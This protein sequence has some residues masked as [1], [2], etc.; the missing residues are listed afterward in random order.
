M[1]LNGP[2]SGRCQQPG[3]TPFGAG[4]AAAAA[5]PPRPPATA[6]GRR[7]PRSARPRP[8]PG[9]DP[10][11]LARWLAGS[12]QRAGATGSR[13]PHPTS[14]MRRS[15]GVSVRARSAVRSAIWWC[16]RPSQPLS[17]L[18]ARASNAAMSRSRVMAGSSQPGRISPRSA[19]INNSIPYE[20]RQR[21]AAARCAYERTL[22]SRAALGCRRSVGGRL[23]RISRRRTPVTAMHCRICPYMNRVGGGVAP[24]PL[25]PPDMRVRIRRFVRPF[26]R[27]AAR[28]GSGSSG[29]G[30]SSRSLAGI[31]GGLGSLQP[32]SISC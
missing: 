9:P 3:R 10:P 31:P 8:W 29:R 28:S 25:T 7:W 15:A 14:R 17:Q 27:A 23:S 4:L 26:G 18:P 20:S 32:A 24:P 11:Q 12:G 21:I 2:E 6:A 22:M 5:P 16:S 13:V 30:G 19:P 1:P